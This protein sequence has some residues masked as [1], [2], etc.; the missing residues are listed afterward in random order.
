MFILLVSL[1]H[2][3]K[4]QY[5]LPSLRYF[6]CHTKLCFS[7]C[8]FDAVGPWTLR[9]RRWSLTS[10]PST[11]TSAPASP[12]SAAR[13]GRK[14]R[15][16]FVRVHGGIGELVQHGDVTRLVAAVQAM[17]FGS[18]HEL[19]MREINV[20][21]LLPR[22]PCCHQ[23][24]RRAT[25]FSDFL[26]FLH[27]VLFGVPES[28][29]LTIKKKHCERCPW[30][31][32]SPANAAREPQ[33]RP[34]TSASMSCSVAT[35][36]AWRCRCV[37]SSWWLMSCSMASFSSLSTNSWMAVPMPCSVRRDS[38]TVCERTF[39][40]DINKCCVSVCV[41]VRVRAQYLL[42]CLKVLFDQVLD[43]QTLNG[44][45]LDQLVVVDVDLI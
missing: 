34:L 25:H 19:R 31:E 1:A 40:A 11:G 33:R 5:V 9:A 39:V 35:P 42:G 27:R 4:A 43:S 37:F 38:C 18:V 45:V 14:R 30:R 16:A 41:C 24:T 10:A 7:L 28:Q 36:L 22:P 17:S 6:Y 2:L 12:S 26:L 3:L 21:R 29:N 32:P 44:R 15:G 23:I 20:K 8:G 13:R